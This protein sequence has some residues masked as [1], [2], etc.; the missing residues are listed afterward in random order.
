MRGESPD[1]W[2][3]WLGTG[4]GCGVTAAAPRPAFAAE[5]PMSQVMPD[6]GAVSTD[7]EV[8]PELYHQAVRT[9]LEHRGNQI[10]M[11]DVRVMFIAPSGQLQNIDFGNNRIPTKP[12]GENRL[13]FMSGSFEYKK[14]AAEQCCS[15]LCSFSSDCLVCLVCLVCL[16]FWFGKTNQ[17]NE[18]NQIDQTNQIDQLGFRFDAIHPTPPLAQSVAGL[19]SPEAV[20]LLHIIPGVGHAL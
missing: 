9:M 20:R 1:N 6:F 2:A 16:I 7:G 17:T 10:L 13:R 14:L 19:L 18:M 11:R 8:L 3:D 15:L 4:L 12:T 5:M